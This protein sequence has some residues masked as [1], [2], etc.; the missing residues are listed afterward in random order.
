MAGVPVGRLVAVPHGEF[1][2]QARRPMY[3]VLGS[4][5]GDLMPTL[6]SALTR[7]VTEAAYRLPLAIAAPREPACA[8]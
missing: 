2:W 6:E 1:A 4:A 8:A 3:S 5:R 7:Y